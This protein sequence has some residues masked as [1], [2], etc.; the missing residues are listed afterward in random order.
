MAQRND[1]FWGYHT[2]LS[3]KDITSLHKS[4]GKHTIQNVN[5]VLTDLDETIHYFQ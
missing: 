4:S 2:V 5:N 3:D 1:C